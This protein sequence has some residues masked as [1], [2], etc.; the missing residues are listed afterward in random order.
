MF[1]LQNGQQPAAQLPGIHHK[2]L[3]GSAQGLRHLSIWRQ[4]IAGG[5]ATPPHHHD[6]EEVVLVASGQGELHIAGQMVPFGPEATLLIPPNVDHQILNTGKETLC[7]TA[8]FS[9][10]PVQVFLPD[11]QPLPLPWDS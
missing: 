6:C 8:A 11:G 2:T 5:Q 4:E 7:I 10:S 9:T 1:I 3:A